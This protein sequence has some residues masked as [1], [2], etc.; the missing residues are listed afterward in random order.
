MHLLFLN[1][2]SLRAKIPAHEPSFMG[3]LNPHPIPDSWDSHALLPAFKV[4]VI[5][6]SSFQASPCSHLNM[7]LAITADLFQDLKCFRAS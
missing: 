2:T 5:S 3:P 4:S 6:L 1:A 7:I